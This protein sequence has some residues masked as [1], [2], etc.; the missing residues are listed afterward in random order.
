MSYTPAVFAVL[1]ANA[2]ALPQT[3]VLPQPPARSPWA[4]LGT[5]GL[6]TV[7]AFYLAKQSDKPPKLRSNRRPFSGKPTLTA[8]ERRIEKAFDAKVNMSADEIRK[9]HRDPRS[10]EAS[11]PHTRAELP[12]LADMLET[13]KA[14]W[15][16]EMRD[17]A[18][19]VVNFI[20][21]HEAQMRAQGKRFGTGALHC[22]RDR[23]IALL[24]WGRKTPGCSEVT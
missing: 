17:K 10:K 5:F 14:E 1:G 8:K 22:T 23:Q 24:N 3:P 2:P 7:A 4:I 16:P 13:P 12:L 21:R 15:S 6:L 18:K 20:N 9:W 11:F 19:R